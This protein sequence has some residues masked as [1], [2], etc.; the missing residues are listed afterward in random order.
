MGTFN[1]PIL[2][3]DLLGGD[4]VETRALVDTGAS[5]L[6]LPR[7]MLVRLGVSALERRSF[8]LADGRHVEYDVGMVSLRLDGRSFPVLCVFG[9]EGAEPILGAVALE[10][11]GLGVDPV[12]QRLVPV[13]G[14]LMLLAR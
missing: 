4:Y 10:I 5:Y 2:V 14:R 13:P 9:E 7:T 3:G 8:V 1:I 6:V 12:G 11:F